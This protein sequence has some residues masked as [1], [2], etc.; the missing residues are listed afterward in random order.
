[1]LAEIPGRQYELDWARTDEGLEILA[2]STRGLPGGY[3]LGAQ[4]S[5]DLL[6]A[7]LTKWVFQAVVCSPGLP[8]IDLKRWAGAADYLVK[9]QFRP[10][11]SNAASAT[12]SRESGRVAG[13]LRASP[14]RRV[15]NGDW[16]ALTR[17]FSGGHFNALRHRDGSLLE[18]RPSANLHF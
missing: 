17:R 9:G 1:L 5:L 8:E 18:R 11:P 15:R 14:A 6:H 10:I 16:L 2:Q 4:N 3:H 12:P 7:R 13:C